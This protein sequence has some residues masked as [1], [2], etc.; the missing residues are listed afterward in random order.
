MPPNTEVAEDRRMADMLSSY[1][2]V[3]VNESPYRP[4]LRAHFAPLFDG[5]MAPLRRRVMPTTA[6]SG[7]E[8]LSLMYSM[9]SDG[10][11]KLP[12]NK[13]GLR[14]VS[15]QVTRAGRLLQAV[16]PLVPVA[17]GMLSLAPV[18]HVTD[19]IPSTIHPQRPNDWRWRHAH[20]TVTLTR[21][22]TVAEVVVHVT[23]PSGPSR[24]SPM[25]HEV[26][27]FW[28]VRSGVPSCNH[29]WHEERRAEGTDTELGRPHR[30]AMLRYRCTKCQG[31]RSW[32]TSHHRGD[33]ARGVK[34]KD[35]IIEGD[36]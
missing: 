33:P 3:G 9:L 21:P 14:L 31:L 4:T 12:D 15:E 17:L 1:L 26:M 27:G 20:E 24:A 34:S 13:A 35:Y 23:Q 36:A 18:R 16:L 19:R 11:M 8:A 22:L 2:L 28:R 7:G 5:W 30:T 32:V 10:Q 6:H 29:V 25:L